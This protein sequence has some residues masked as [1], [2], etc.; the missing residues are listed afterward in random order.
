MV[1]RS[2][3]GSRSRFGC[4]VL[5]GWCAAIA[6]I[7]V[8]AVLALLP[9]FFQRFDF[10]RFL[11]TP[12][13]EIRRAAEKEAPAPAA[14]V[15]AEAPPGERTLRAGGLLIRYEPSSPDAGAA[16][17][18]PGVVENRGA[19]TI[20]RLVVG[21]RIAAPDGAARTED[22]DVLKNVPLP[23]GGQR[24]FVVHPSDAPAGWTPG[25]VSLRIVTAE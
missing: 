13:E 22:F 6:L 24:R 12:V 19:T 23:P 18:V 1:A 17:F 15:E 10:R 11:K 14:A 5:I 3:P 7:A 21:M 25:R 8:A 4:G 2:Q 20:H 9:H 16:P